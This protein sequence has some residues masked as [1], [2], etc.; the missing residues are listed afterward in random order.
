MTPNPATMTVQECILFVQGQRVLE[1]NA[2]YTAR[3]PV[4]RYYD[5]PDPIE[6]TLDSAAT[7]MP[8]GWMMHSLR[9]G[10]LRRWQTEAW[11]D[12]EIV[13]AT[14]D[15]ELLARWRLVV[16]CMMAEK[17]VGDE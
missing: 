9:Q 7:A 4:D 5:D 2:K 14:A 1:R 8:N 15:T 17:E 12:G 3:T 16:A 13:A 11:K 10:V 6:P